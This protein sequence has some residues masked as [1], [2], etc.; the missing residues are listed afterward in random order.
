MGV[1]FEPVFQ[2][3]EDFYD[4]SIDAQTMIAKIQLFDRGIIGKTD[5]RT[6]LRKAG[7]VEREDEEIEA[8]AIDQD[9]TE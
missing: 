9:P 5:L 2:I 4:K 3:N 8:E 7:E 1:T 6:T